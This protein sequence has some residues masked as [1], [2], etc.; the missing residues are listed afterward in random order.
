MNRLHATLVAA[1]LAPCACPAAIVNINGDA[2]VTFES[3]TAFGDPLS[4]DLAA[5]GDIY[6]DMLGDSMTIASITATDIWIW[7]TAST[8]TFPA[9]PGT[10]SYASVTDNDSADVTGSAMLLP[11]QDWLDA[12]FT[13]NSNGSI[14]IWNV[15]SSVIIGGEGSS[16]TINTGSGD[17]TICTTPDCSVTLGD[18]GGT[19]VIGGGDTPII[20][21]PGN[22]FPTPQVPLPASWLLFASGLGLLG[23]RRR[24]ATG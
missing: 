15:G 22:I 9:W 19:I 17:V 6:L 11:E 10:T 4:V 18:G 14:Y 13:L 7:D 24:S 1:L 12:L 5:S 8:P 16:G 21:I 23:L 2:E 3:A 20:D